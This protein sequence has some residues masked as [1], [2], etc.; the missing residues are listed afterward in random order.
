METCQIIIRVNLNIKKVE[1]LSWQ[2]LVL[3]MAAWLSEQ[4]VCTSRD[5]Q[6]GRNKNTFRSL[7][8][9]KEIS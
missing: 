1:W 3:A 4:D 6:I 8:T 9:L 2:T 7:T 5:K